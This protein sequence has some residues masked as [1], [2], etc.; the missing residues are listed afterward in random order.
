MAEPSTALKRVTKLTIRFLVDNN[1]EWMTKLP[2]GFTHELHQHIPHS[3]HTTGDKGG[4]PVL[5]FNDFCCGAHG[6]AALIETELDEPSGDGNPSNKA[7]QKQLY[8][9]LFDTGPDALSL[10]RNIRALQVPIT[11][12]D[13]VVTSHWH[14]DHTGGLISFLDLRKKHA[15][16][17]CIVNVHPSRPHLRGI[18]PPPHNNHV[19]CTLPPD[20]TFEAIEAAGGVLEKRKDGHAVAGNTVWVSGEVPRVTEWEG[21]L[22]GGVRWVE[23]GE[24]GWKSEPHLMDERYAVVDVEGKGLVVFSSCS[25]AGIVNVA[26]DAVKTFKRPIYMIVGG[27]HLASADLYPR[28]EPTVSFFSKSLRPSPTYI[29]PMHCTGWKAKLALESALGEGIVPTGVGHKVE[30][31]GIKEQGEPGR[32]TLWV[33][34]VD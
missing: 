32:S 9:T 7:S 12:I 19:L 29:L 15:V 3:R 22:L 21:G 5:D 18:A 6:F 13:R 11:T 4:V 27:L 1:L 24:E 2:P 31:G 20:P 28:I 17:P 25:H 14:S 10:V 34:V 16:K 23:A 33:Q 30:V 8:R 26:K